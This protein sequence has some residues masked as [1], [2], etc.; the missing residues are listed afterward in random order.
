MAWIWNTLWFPPLRRCLPV[1]ITSGAILP[2]VALVSAQGAGVVSQ[3]NPQPASLAPPQCQCDPKPAA[4]LEDRSWKETTAFAGQ[5][6]L[7]VANPTN[8]YPA[9][10]VK[11]RK[12]KPGEWL[13]TNLWGIEA[14]RLIRSDLLF[15]PDLSGYVY[16]ETMFLPQDRQVVCELYQANRPETPI[17]G[18]QQARYQNQNVLPENL[19]LPL[20]EKP[21]HLMRPVIPSQNDSDRAYTD[22]INPDKLPG[23][24]VRIVGAGDQEKS[25]FSFQTIVPVDWSPDGRL[26]VMLTRHGILHEAATGTDM[27]VYDSQQG[28][29]R[30]YPELWR[31]FDPPSTSLTTR[32]QPRAFDV[33]PMGFKTASNS[34][35][36]Y[37]V[38]SY[39]LPDPFSR[40][41][42]NVD[43][44][45]LGYWVYNLKTNAN[46]LLSDRITDRET[47]LKQ[48]TVN[49]WL[50]AVQPTP[51][52]TGPIV[53][54]STDL[55][56]PYH[57]EP[58]TDDRRGK[59]KKPP[60][61]YWH[62]E[63]GLYDNFD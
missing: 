50:G 26:L 57:R 30:I 9:G 16:T 14:K 52:T 45:F 55:N 53:G 34:E 38:R 24:K 49:G 25:K 43:E 40:K 36:V 62:Y 13:H 59:K 48:V 35:I 60:L 47:V 63:Y 19:Q 32:Q 58:H 5:S 12:S 1:V 18:S 31:R 28:I 51:R 2:L 44:R 29:V 17:P 10:S 41:P 15:K 33:V 42:V 37:A 39:K 61:K 21:R 27:M 22:F 56:H 6:A 54:P 3:L 4:P 46:R 23:M 11:F 8:L 20:E 7:S